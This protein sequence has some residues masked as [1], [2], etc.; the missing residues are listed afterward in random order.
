MTN[1]KEI[2]NE[3]TGEKEFLFNA[4]LLKMGETILENSN[5]TEF[6]IATIGFEL[7]N[8]DAVQRTAICYASSYE[9]GVE[10]DEN[11]LCN[12]SFSE[13]D[14]EPQLRMSHL[15]NALRAT[16]DDFAGLVEMKQQVIQPEVVL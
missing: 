11:Y 14:G 8:G 5:G 9:Q 7:P 10:V 2:I 4:K 3:L 12:L 6:K 13:E 16:S 15:S 1:Y